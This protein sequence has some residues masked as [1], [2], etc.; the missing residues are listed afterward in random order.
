MYTYEI[1]GSSP[2]FTFSL[3][4]IY[5]EK[6]GG[7][8]CCKNSKYEILGENKLQLYAVDGKGFFGIFTQE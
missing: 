2:F 3:K 5:E 8:K 6:T 1:D 7:E 4:N